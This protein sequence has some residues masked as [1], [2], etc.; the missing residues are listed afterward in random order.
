MQANRGKRGECRGADPCTKRILAMAIQRRARDPFS[1]GRCSR[2]DH[3]RHHAA[4]GGSRF[5]Q[6][7]ESG[8]ASPRFK[9][10]LRALDCPDPAFTVF[11]GCLD[12]RLLS[13]GKSIPRSHGMGFPQVPAMARRSEARASAGSRPRLPLYRHV[14]DQT[15]RSRCAVRLKHI[16]DQPVR[17]E[18]GRASGCGDGD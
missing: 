8:F 5:H 15:V 16:G 2:G 3:H 10:A 14:V 18:G 4:S 13:A 17:S 11:C 9:P 12:R 1:I 7:Q 6:S